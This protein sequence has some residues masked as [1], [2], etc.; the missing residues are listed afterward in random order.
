[1][2]QNTVVLEFRQFVQKVRKIYLDWHNVVAAKPVDAKL[3]VTRIWCLVYTERGRC[4]FQKTV[5]KLDQVAS[6]TCT[7][8]KHQWNFKGYP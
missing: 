5:D 3:K 1:M 7:R 2:K 4:H 6:T 8:E